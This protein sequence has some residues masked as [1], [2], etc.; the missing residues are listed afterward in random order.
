M[1][2]SQLLIVLE[3]I[4]RE[5]PDLRFGQLI[6]NIIITYHNNHTSKMGVENDLWNWTNE[7]WIKAIYLFKEKHK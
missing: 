5:Y 1:Q 2:K 6:E 7:Q 3:E 4:W